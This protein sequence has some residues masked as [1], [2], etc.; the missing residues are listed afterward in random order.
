MRLPAA[1]VS[2]WFNRLMAK[3]NEKALAHFKER[4]EGYNRSSNWVRDAELL[5]KIFDAAGVRGGE[6]VL[7]LATGTGLVARQFRGKV[8]E[9]V[10]LDISTEMTGQAS[11]NLDRLI[12]S[13]ME[14]IP[15]E[16]GAVDVCVCRQGLQFSELPKAMRE[17]A[18]VL[19]PG[20]RAVFCHL[21][22]YGGED[23]EDAFKIQ[24]LRNP[25]RV[26]FF[27]PGDLESILEA[28]GLTVTGTSRHLSRESVN[29]WIEHGASTVEER[30]S[31][32]DAYRG[33]S[34]AFKR[35]HRIEIEGDDIFDTMLFLIIR[36]EKKA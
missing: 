11:A 26:N 24:A 10:G 3:P 31:I 7:D 13:P 25:S 18:R 1:L 28:S 8:K 9:V 34:E 22:A 5:K 16:S 6:T 27:V 12:I 29:Q 23:R 20:G 4:S 33:A 14:S 21:N 15:L 19:R 30:K 35:I 2:L 32:K 36:A 17:V